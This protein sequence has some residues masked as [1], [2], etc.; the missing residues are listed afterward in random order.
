MAGTRATVGCDFLMDVIFT[1]DCPTIKVLKEA[2]AIILVKG[3]LPQIA[4]SLHSSNRLYGGTCQNP[5]DRTRSCGGSSGGDAG[6]VASRCVPLAI[7]T[8]LGGSQR[9]PG[10]F[11]G[12]RAFKFT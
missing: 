6:L 4:L 8:D 10:H 2:G 5:Y 3:N 1:E 12:L 11:C 9:I 7:G